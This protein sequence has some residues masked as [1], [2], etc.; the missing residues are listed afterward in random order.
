MRLGGKA[1]CPPFKHQTR[2]SP[3][4]YRS[5]CGQRDRSTSLSTSPATLPIPP[6]KDVAVCQLY[7]AP[8][9]VDRNSDVGVISLQDGRL[10]AIDAGAPSRIEIVRNNDDARIRRCNAEAHRAR[11][12]FRHCDF[13]ICVAPGRTC[14]ITFWEKIRCAGC[15][16]GDPLG[17]GVKHIVPNAGRTSIG[18]DAPVTEQPDATVISA[19]YPQRASILLGD[20]PP[21]VRGAAVW[22]NMYLTASMPSASASRSLQRGRLT[23]CGRSTSRTSYLSR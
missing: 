20:T 23:Q 4:H 12:I 14:G 2:R 8:T 9:A 19:T 18:G 16:E 17:V 6:K 13:R 7:G 15:N 21:A 5:V 1:D 10:P 3:S 11:P 22:Q